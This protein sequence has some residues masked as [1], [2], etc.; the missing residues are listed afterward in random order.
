MIF[1]WSDAAV[2]YKIS[3]D[4]NMSVILQKRALVLF[5]HPMEG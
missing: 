2:D 3:G 5:P 1:R 4:K